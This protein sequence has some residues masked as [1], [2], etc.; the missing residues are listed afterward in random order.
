MPETFLILLA[1]GV[2]LAAALSDPRQ[3]TLQW[4]RLAGVIALCMTGLCVYFFVTRDAVANTPA[5]F[6]RIQVGLLVST[7]LAVL[8]QLAFAQ[9]AKRRTQRILASAAFV[10]AVLAGSNLL[11]DAMLVREAAAGVK[12]NLPPK[13]LA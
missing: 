2:M 7:A 3:V 11:H 10:L 1:G 12:L 6:R 9:L 4:L 13:P 5:F 8:S